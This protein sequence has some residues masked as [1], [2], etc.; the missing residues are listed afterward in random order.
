MHEVHD[1]VIGFMDGSGAAS[2][3]GL[4]LS[5][6]AHQFDRIEAY[7]K[8]C[9]GRGRTPDNV[10]TW[11]EIP[12]VPI[13]AFKHLVLCCAEPE[14]VFLS[15]GTTAGPALRSAHRMPDLRLYHRSALAG[16]RRFLFPDVER[17][18]LAVL[19]HSPAERPDSS[20]SQ[21]AG[22]AVEEF[23]TADSD[24]LVRGTAIDHERCLEVL[25]AAER[26]GR[27]LCLMATT[28]ALIRVLDWMRERDLAVRLPH[29]SR[30]MDTGGDKGAPRPMSRNGLLHACWAAFAVPGYFVVNE[31]GMAEL[32]SQFYDSVIFD[33][34]RGRHAPRVKLG[35][36]WTRTLVVDPAT[37]QPVAEGERGLLCH[38][39]LANAGTAMAVLA[40]D[41]G[42]AAGEGFELLGRAAAAEVRGCSLALAEMK[43]GSA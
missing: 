34:V 23:G 20:L 14:R 27:P 22:W 28:A 38:F 35:P 12:A 15:T 42:R 6:F 19:I 11:T 37:L 17:L 10:R 1:A 3:D 18:T 8:F 43:E 26:S 36:P 31:Y 4:A 39:D 32:S 33:R 9:V 7:R 2:F 30:V 41:V 29:G 25:R 40:E 24:W 13:L 21:M 5:V 16:L